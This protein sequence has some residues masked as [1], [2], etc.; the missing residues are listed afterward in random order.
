MPGKAA[1]RGVYTVTDYHICAVVGCRHQSEPLSVH[2]TLIVI[3]LPQE[4]LLY[5]RNR[6]RGGEGKKKKKGVTHDQKL[7]IAPK[8]GGGACRGGSCR[9]CVRCNCVFWMVREEIFG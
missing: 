4:Q 3:E 1:R 5:L 8:W 2:L 7:T 9:V 6:G